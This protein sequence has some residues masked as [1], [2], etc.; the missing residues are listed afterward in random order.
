MKGEEV[1]NIA[2]TDMSAR[3]PAV[4]QRLGY[5]RLWIEDQLLNENSEETG[6][7]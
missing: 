1:K 5:A 6:L 2:V 3:L 4:R 7:E